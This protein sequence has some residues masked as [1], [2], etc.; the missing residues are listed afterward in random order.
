M[1]LRTFIADFL[2]LVTRVAG[3]PLLGQSLEGPPEERGKLGARLASVNRADGASSA[4]FGPADVAF[5]DR[6]RKPASS[7]DASALR[8]SAVARTLAAFVAALACVFGAGW[9]ASAQEAADAEAPAPT[10]V[11]VEDAGVDAA[12]GAA[13]PPGAETP[14]AETFEEWRVDFRTRA[15]ASGRAEEFVDA[16]LD[17]LEP[18]ERVIELDRNQPEFVRPVWDYL[19]S[20]VSENRVSR[21]RTLKVEIAPL[22]GELEERYRVDAPYL[23]AIWALESYYGGDIG[24]FDA[25]RSMATLAWEGRRREMFETELL[26]MID[27]IASGDARRE[28]FVSGW[29][30]ALG[31]T[32]FKPSIYI[33]FAVDHDEDGR[34]DIW[35][36]RADALASA[37]NYLSAHGWRD[38]EPWGVEVALPESFEYAAADGRRRSVGSWA[39]EGVVRADGEP[40]SPSEQLLEARL[41]LAAGA[42]GP[43]FLTYSNFEVFRRYNNAT[44]YALAAGLLGDAISEKTGVEASWPRHERP[45]TR[46]EIEELQALLSGLGYDTQ[47]VDGRVGPNTR[48]ALRAFQAD[49]EMPADAFAT[50]SLLERARVDAAGGD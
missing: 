33:A 28:D 36:N 37:A 27:I 48:T 44:S 16:V 46:E 4:S 12:P 25:A 39:V 9:A 13:T 22:L 50:A 40:W 30:G 10:A 41:L 23:L 31:Q 43:A 47:G 7:E 6:E 35:R 3:I 24:N 38:N 2:D 18:I 26:A 45:L 11:E 8:S 20:A 42:D 32:Q 17:G 1:E 49:R 14:G 5:S 29:A 21:G 34:K 19:D 15:I